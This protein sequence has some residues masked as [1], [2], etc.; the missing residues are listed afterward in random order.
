[1]GPV[2]ESMG[3]RKGVMQHMDQDK[4]MVSL[5]FHCPTRGL[6]GY[7]S[8]F[9]TQT[10]GLGTMY[11]VFLDYRESV[12]ELK[13]R[14]CGVLVSKETAPTVSYALDNLQDRG[15]LFIGPGVDVYEG[16][17]IGENS[18][19]D[20]MVVNPAKSKKLTNVRASGSDDAVMLTPPVKMSLEQ[21]MAFIDDTEL[22]ECTPESIRIRK[23]FLKENERKVR[24]QL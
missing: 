17:I 16:Q 2:I 21:Y 6:L 14:K 8:E 9:M 5:L 7:Q 22:I 4:G 12:G 19:E 13:T 1:M 10:K 18:R 23:I 20:D 15:R 11:N 3:F 24:K